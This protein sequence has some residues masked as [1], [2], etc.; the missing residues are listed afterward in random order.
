M[1]RIDLI[2]RR[3]DSI[4]D[5][6]H[7]FDEFLNESLCFFYMSFFSLHVVV[8]GWIDVSRGFNESVT[9][10]GLAKVLD[11]ITLSIVD[12]R[13]PSAEPFVET[14]VARTLLQLLEFG[15]HILLL[16]LRCR[17]DAV[18]QCNKLPTDFM[19]PEIVLLELL[20]DSE[21]YPLRDFVVL[22]LLAVID[23]LKS[24]KLLNRIIASR[25]WRL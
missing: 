15:P 10:L 2:K 8:E 1:A 25:I 6:L 16:V 7:G 14:D 3:E 19:D 24:V 12:E 20:T 9:D 17:L 13:G 4:R 23:R 22:L 18:R 5:L 11:F 21:V